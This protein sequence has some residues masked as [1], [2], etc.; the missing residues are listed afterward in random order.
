MS[1]S[2]LGLACRVDDEV[3]T[4]VKCGTPGYVGPEILKGQL[5][6]TKAD[7]FSLGCFLFN[8]ISS[9]SLFPGRN[10]K[11]VL[12]SNRYSDP[13]QGVT[14]KVRN[15]SRE[16]K[17]LLRWMLSVDP[18]QRPSAEECLSH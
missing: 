10:M 9:S 12:A 3:E 6:T 8:M 7:I 5:V 17:D 1:I 13:Q 2:D 16:C 15:V 18:N 11:E 4:R 14:E